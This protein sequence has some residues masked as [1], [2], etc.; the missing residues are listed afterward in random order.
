MEN[1]LNE[2]EAVKTREFEMSYDDVDYPISS[3]YS[4]ILNMKK[5][6]NSLKE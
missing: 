1:Q 2:I 4:I 6:E 5:I 3:K